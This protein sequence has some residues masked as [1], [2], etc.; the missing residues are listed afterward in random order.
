M[1]GVLGRVTIFC[2]HS[3]VHESLPSVE[4][5]GAAVLAC[6][7]ALEDALVTRGCFHKLMSANSKDVDQ[8]TRCYVMHL[9]FEAGLPELRRGALLLFGDSRLLFFI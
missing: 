8:E 7:E 5:T 3:G 2:A 4:A 9:V 1:V 6:L